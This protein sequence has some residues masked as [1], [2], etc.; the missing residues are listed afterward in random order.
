MHVQ[1]GSQ[2]P[3]QIIG[4]LFR[5]HQRYRTPTKAAFGDD[6]V[7]VVILDARLAIGDPWQRQ[8]LVSADLEIGVDDCRPR[9]CRGQAFRR[10]GECNVY[11]TGTFH[12]SKQSCH[13]LHRPCRHRPADDLGARHRWIAQCAFAVFMSLGKGSHLSEVPRANASWISVN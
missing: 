8:R 11:C 5:P 1:T 9:A 10:R 7:D 2:E 12:G 3:L 13:I 6:H 4:E